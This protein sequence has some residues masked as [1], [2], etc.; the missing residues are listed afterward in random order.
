[1][2]DARHFADEVIVYRR[3]RNTLAAELV[4]HTGHAEIRADARPCE[5]V[6]GRENRL[7]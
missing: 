5:S 7:V 4:H 1:V 2:H 3:R 6:N